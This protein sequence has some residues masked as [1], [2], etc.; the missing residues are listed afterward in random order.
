VIQHLTEDDDVRSM[1]H[2]RAA[3]ATVSDD[4]WDRIAARLAEP[5]PSRTGRRLAVAGVAVAAAAGTVF[6]A[7]VP[8]SNVASEGP[9][10]TAAAPTTIV[11]P[12]GEGPVETAS[13]WLADALPEVDLPAGQL[14]GSED[15]NATVLFRS[16]VVDTELYVRQLSGRP[17]WVVVGAA[18]DLVL[19]SDVTFDGVELTGRA[20]PG[21]DGEIE[22][23][24]L[25]DVRLGAG[26]DRPAPARED[27]M[28]G[29]Q[30]TDPVAEAAVRVVLRTDGPTGLSYARGER[31]DDPAVSD[32]AYVA[33]WPATDTEGLASLQQQADEGKR[34]DLLEPEA[35]AGAFL[36]EL[37]PRGESVTSYAVGEFRRGDV[38]SGEVPYTLSTGGGGTILLRNLGEDGSIWFVAGAVSDDLQLVET[39]REE[40][41]LVADVQSDLAGAL[42]WTGATSIRVSPGQTV[43]I[44]RPD[45]PV[46]AYPV[47][48]R[49]L[50]GDRT[51]AILATV[52]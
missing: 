52:S 23:T 20:T 12:V 13:R 21:V 42:T 15:G 30:A 35:V 29:Y 18:S 33:V 50:D 19:L 46:G 40:T 48:V 36:A 8:G 1:L 7:N 45:T 27:V 43:S 6:A 31:I 49:L 37:L 41:H 11:A 25:L 44:G 39:R 32:G 22:I 10:T 17:G 26:G 4:A 14:Q 9:T 16:D 28:L 3:S 24:Y 34:P 2:A 38:T 51:L 5:T 47:V